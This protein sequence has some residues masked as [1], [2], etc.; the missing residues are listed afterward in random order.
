MSI[1]N[2]SSN[3][4][5]VTQTAQQIGYCLFNNTDFDYASLILEYISMR[6]N[7]KRQVIYFSRFLHLIF[8]HLIP[9][10]VLQ[11]ETCMKV[12]KNGPRSFVDMTNKDVKNEFNTPIVYPQQIMALL[13]GR[14]PDVYG[15]RVQESTEGTH[16]ESNPKHTPQTLF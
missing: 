8:V 1:T 14:L 11:N 12:H 2:K 4:D 7:D 10:V 9:N 5:A 6:L 15:A 16:S 3:F 13:R